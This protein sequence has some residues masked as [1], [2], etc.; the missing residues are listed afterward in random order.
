MNKQNEIKLTL[1][2]SRLSKDKDS[3]MS[4]ALIK[5]GRREIVGFDYQRRATTYYQICKWSSQK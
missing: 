2:T 4:K 1:D 3:P 5:A